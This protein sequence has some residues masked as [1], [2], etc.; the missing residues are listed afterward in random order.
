MDNLIYKNSF[1]V[2]SFNLDVPERNDCMMALWNENWAYVPTNESTRNLMDRYSDIE[3]LFPDELKGE[4]LPYFIY[5]LINKVL[6]LEIDTPS[7]DEAHTIFLTMNDRGLSLNS[8]EMLKAFIIQQVDEKDRD[9][10]NR[11]WQDNINRVK[12]ASGAQSS[13]TVRAEDVDF[14]LLQKQSGILK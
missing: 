9:L 12:S 6:L 8:A 1:G 3:D 4:G 2:M 14:I 5:S 10:V 11:Q 13:G 7:E